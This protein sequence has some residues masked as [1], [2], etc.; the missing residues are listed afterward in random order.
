MWIYVLKN[1]IWAALVLANTS[2][3]TQVY[4]MLFEDFEL[5]SKFGIN[6]RYILNKWPKYIYE[7]GDK[8]TYFD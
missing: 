1:R 5:L 8:T 4:Q 3:Q 2:L 7:P 6:V